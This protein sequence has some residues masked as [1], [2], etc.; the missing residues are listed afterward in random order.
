MVYPFLA[1]IWLDV[2][3]RGLV[4]TVLITHSA[5]DC[6]CTLCCLFPAQFA[7]PYLA[8]MYVS[9]FRETINYENA[10]LSR[11]TVYWAAAMSLVRA[12]ALWFQTVELFWAVVI[13][14]VLEGLVAQYEGFNTGTIKRKTARLITLFSFG[15]AF[16]LSHVLLLFP[17]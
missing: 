10:A 3:L 16:L 14:Y 6:A 5:A 11:V 1:V 2:V 12:L 4:L 9:I 13:M 17:K 7:N 8:T 15:F